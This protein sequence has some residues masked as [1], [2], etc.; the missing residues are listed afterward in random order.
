MTGNG[1]VF[2][3]LWSIR[4]IALATFL[5]SKNTSKEKL[6][7][8][9]LPLT[10]FEATPRRLPGSSPVLIRKFE[11][12]THGGL[13]SHVT[14]LAPFAVSEDFAMFGYGI[15]MGGA[16]G[17]GVLQTSGNAEVIPLLSLCTTERLLTPTVTPI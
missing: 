3:S 2:L 1:G 13:P 12:F 16:G 11:S 7:N 8:S 14:V 4:S 6:T 15:G 5:P 9:A 10:L 17:A